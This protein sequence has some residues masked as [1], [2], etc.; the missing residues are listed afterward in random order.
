M[1]DIK[2]F[3][4]LGLPIQTEIGN[5]HFIKVQDYPD[6]FMDLQIVALTKNHIIS[7]Y[8]EMNKDGSLT[9]FIDELHKIELFEIVAGIPEIKE[10]Y[11]RL[12][13][14]VFDEDSVI[15]KVT[16]ENFYYLRN[17]VMTMNCLKEEKVN[18]N[19]EIQRAMERSRR[20]K[21]REGDKLEFADIVT[22]V[23][24]HNGLT[25]DDI[26]NFSI[27]QL[28]MTYYRIA[29]FKNYDTSTLFATV[30]ADKVQIDSWSKHINLFEEETHSIE[31]DK[32]KQTT[33]SVFDE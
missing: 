33:G 6:S 10:S 19:P 8:N 22:S 31:H 2:E 3:Y 12:F 30:A 20:V 11:F 13:S 1:M 25:Y 14:K 15:E 27:Y 17:L 32:F 7:K 26:N 5:C 9:G 16:Q 28:Y 23:V 18:P 29:Q 24:G 21:A 4:I